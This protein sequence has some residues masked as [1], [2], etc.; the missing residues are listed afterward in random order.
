MDW[1]TRA[2]MPIPRTEVAAATVDKNE[3]VVLGG[4][5]HR[6]WRLASRGRVFARARYLEASAGHPDW[7]ASLDRRRCGRAALRHRR[8]HGRRWAVAAPDR[9]SSSN[10]VG[11]ARFLA[12]RSRARRREPA[13]LRRGPDHR[14][15][16]DR[17]R[18][19]ARAERPV[20]R[21][22]HEPV[23]G[24]RGPHAARA[25]GSSVAWPAPCTRSAVELP[26]STPTSS[27]SR[28]DRPGDRA[29]RKLSMP[30]LDPLGGVQAQP[31]FSGVIVSV[32]GEEL[33]GTIAEVLAYRI[34]ERRWV[35]LGTYR[36]HVTAW[37][38]PLSADGY[39]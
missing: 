1:E 14:R 2:P 10:A 39:S 12:C 28:S 18:S 22:C 23:G 35:E 38:S 6:W 29:W 9:H 20:V 19:P 30:F 17:R 31:A 32:G 33:G 3:I 34:A 36:P 15:G 8:V 26:A 4:L 16:W 21:P 27:T 13:R 11:G 24:Y 25:P 37:A 7:R 5:D